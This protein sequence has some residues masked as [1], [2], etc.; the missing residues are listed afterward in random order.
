M[1]QRGRESVWWTLPVLR[2]VQD[3]RL[4]NLLPRKKAGKIRAGKVFAR[5]THSMGHGFQGS[6]AG[7]VSDSKTADRNRDH[8]LFVRCLQSQARHTPEMKIGRIAEQTVADNI[9]D[10]RGFGMSSYS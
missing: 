4:Y 8:R 7:T 2:S 10:R 1:C 9:P 3:L 5:K 6:P